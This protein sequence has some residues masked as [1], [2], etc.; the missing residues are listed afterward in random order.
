[1]TTPRHTGPV[2]PGHSDQS[3]TTRGQNR[4][5]VSNRLGELRQAS[6]YRQN[7]QRLGPRKTAFNPVQADH[8]AAVVVQR[9][10][11]FRPICLTAGRI[12]AAAFLASRIACPGIR[13]RRTT[14]ECLHL[15]L[16]QKG[17][18][19]QQISG[20]E[21]A[22]HETI[23]RQ[24]LRHSRPMCKLSQGIPVPFVYRGVGSLAIPLR[25]FWASFFSTAWRKNGR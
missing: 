19:Q 5:S 18:T 12:L 10:G 13:H 8:R 22:L 2:F 14:R 24:C 7:A 17:Q 4:R 3:N 9:R 21:E 20:Y 11:F 1:M 16:T 6:W 15:S 25:H 23:P